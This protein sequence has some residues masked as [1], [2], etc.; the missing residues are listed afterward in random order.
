MDF[1]KQIELE[2]LLFSQ[3][4]C[5]TCGEVKSLLDDFYLIR[6]RKAVTP[7]SYSYECKVCTIKRVKAR[8]KASY[9]NMNWEYPDWQ[10]M[11]RF[12]AEKQVFNK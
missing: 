7:S 1:D 11:H 10:F 12:P 9:T 3:R 4:K 6:K 8:K 5:R 2:H